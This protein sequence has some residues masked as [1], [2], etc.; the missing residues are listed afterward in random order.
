MPIPIPGLDTG[1]ISPELKLRL[2]FYCSWT[3]CLCYCFFFLPVL[4]YYC[5]FLI[6]IPIFFFSFCTINFTITTFLSISHSIH[7]PSFFCTIH[8]SPSQLLLPLLIHCLP[9]PS[10]PPT[11]HQT[12]PP[13]YTRIMCWPTYCTN[14][15]QPQP[16]PIP[17][18]STLHYNRNAPKHTQGPQHPAASTSLPRLP[19]PL[20]TSSFSATLTNFTNF[21][22]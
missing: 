18:T 13:S 8:C 20:P 15:T 6:F 19:T 22:S 7:S 16:P 5:G 1:G 11:S 17:D 4:L 2:K 10:P 9:L 3:C 12:T 14:F 21:Y